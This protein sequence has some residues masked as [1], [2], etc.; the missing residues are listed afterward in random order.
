MYIY[1]TIVVGY[2][3]CQNLYN[4]QYHF[5]IYRAEKNYK[6]SLVKHMYIN[7]PHAH[8]VII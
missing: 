5:T 2:V 8:S 6:N 1:N 3:Q 7:K 4:I